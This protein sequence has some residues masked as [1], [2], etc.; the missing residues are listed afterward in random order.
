M[1]AALIVFPSEASVVFTCVAEASTVTVSATVP[2][3]SNLT[4]T[5]AGVFTS[6]VMFLISTAEN[7]VILAVRLYVPGNTD[8]RE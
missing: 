4:L 1:A 6:N 7:P 5:V 8:G 3:F 2:T